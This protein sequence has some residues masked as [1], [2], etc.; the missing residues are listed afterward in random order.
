[1]VA[2]TF[3]GSVFSLPG[4]NDHRA[5]FG[6]NFYFAY[7]AIYKFVLDFHVFLFLSSWEAK[8]ETEKGRKKPPRQS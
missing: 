5:D 7:S 3:V 8:Q 2:T 6:G 4:L 1:M